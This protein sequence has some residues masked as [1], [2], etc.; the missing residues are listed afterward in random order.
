[1]NEVRDI[2]PIQYQIIPLFLTTERGTIWVRDVQWRA[3]SCRRDDNDE[4][5]CTWDGVKPSDSEKQTLSV[6][7]VV[8]QTYILGIHILFYLLYSYT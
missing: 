4:E 1:M 7:P 5:K 2:N 8:Q 6:K 3:V